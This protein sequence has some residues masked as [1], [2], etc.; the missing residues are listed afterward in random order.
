MKVVLFAGGL[1]TRLSEET[2]ARPK[3]MVEIGGKPILWHIMKIYSHYGFNDFIICLGYKGYLIKEYF[4]HY[5]MHNSD[6]TIDIGNNSVQ[7]HGTSSESFKVTLIDTGLTTKTAGRLKQVRKYIGDEDFMLTYGDGVGD[8]DL[9]E[10]LAFHKHN[11][12]IATVTAVQLEARFG[13][14]ELGPDNNV[15]A[16]REKAKDEN[17]WINAGFFVL[18]PQVFDYLEGDMNEM[19]W[20]DEPLEKLAA[21]NQ[22]AAHR[23][24]G[25]WKPMDALRDKIELEALWKNDQAKWKVW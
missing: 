24:Y 11:N 17:K 14:M 2:D 6:L 21:E 23:H 7:V 25:F 4:M 13:G 19:M 22:L 20:E 12:K 10:L 15:V 18:K 8:I 1:G 3:P 9:K 16:F 5:F